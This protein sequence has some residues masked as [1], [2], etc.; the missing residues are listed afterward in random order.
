M[1]DALH[2]T[3][4]DLPQDVADR[5]EVTPPRDPAHGDMATNAAM[6]AARAAKQPPAKLAAAIAERL[7]ASPEIDEATAAGPGFINLRLNPDAL[8]GVL[9][10]I[11]NAGEAFGDSTVGAGAKVNVEY[12]SAN[13]TGPIHVGHC[14]GAVVGDALASLLAKA[15]FDVTREFYINDA[16]AQVAALAWAAYWRYLQAIGT[17]LTEAQFGEEVPGGLQYRGDYLVPVGEELARPTVLHSP[18]RTA[19]SPRPNSGSTPSAISPST[20]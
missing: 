4:P 8:R 5:V 18:H 2:A 17:K 19:R 20:R 13:P 6:V 1:L 11:L 3:V 7:R 15:G 16:G 12:V 10:V 9:P 14:R